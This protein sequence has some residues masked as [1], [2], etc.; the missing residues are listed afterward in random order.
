MT[1]T[2]PAI[3]THTLPTLP[4]PNPPQPRT[5]HAPTTQAMELEKQLQSGTM[6]REQMDELFRRMAVSE[7]KQ[8]MFGDSPIAD[9]IVRNAEPYPLA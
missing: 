2:L 5:N 7:A 4:A 3:N 6:S 8:S 1:R 9:A